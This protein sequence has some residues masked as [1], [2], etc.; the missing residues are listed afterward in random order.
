MFREGDAWDWWHSPEEST[1]DSPPLNLTASV[2]VAASGENG[3]VPVP[4][5]ESSPDSNFWTSHIG[6]ALTAG[7]GMTAGACLVG[8]YL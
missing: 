6:L 4:P 2:V 7:L 8:G 1:S 5:V 3:D